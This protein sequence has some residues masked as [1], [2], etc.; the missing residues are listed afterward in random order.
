MKNYNLTKEAVEFLEIVKKAPPIDLTNLEALKEVRK[1]RKEGYRLLVNIP[2]RI[3]NVKD[4]TIPGPGGDIPLRIYTPP[5]SEVFPVFLYIHGG[6]WVFGSIEESTKECMSIAKKT[7]AIVVS[8]DYRL[9]PEHVFPAAHLDCYRAL[10]WIKENISTFGGNPEKIAVG[11]LSAGATTAIAIT[12]KSIEE[13][14]IHVKFLLPIH[15]V[16]DITVMNT[17]SYRLFGE[18]YDLTK[19]DM[20]YLMP[21]Y[22]PDE[23]DRL[24]PWASPLRAENPEKFPPTLVITAE[25]DILRD[26]G[27]RFAKKLGEAGVRAEYYRSAGNIHNLISSDEIDRA[28]EA[29]RKYLKADID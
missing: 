19:K 14:G 26:E 20:E 18:G 1:L 2:D 7:P 9:A 12:L 11:G 29:L 27:E 17:E 3:D 25:V 15:P 4:I 24:H 16:T 5:G 28:S 22:F 8:V 23:K 13:G 6:G 10:E 21:V